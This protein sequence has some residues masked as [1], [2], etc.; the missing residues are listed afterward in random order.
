MP[1][2]VVSIESLEL[3]TTTETSHMVELMSTMAMRYLDPKQKIPCPKC[4]SGVQRDRMRRHNHSEH[5]GAQRRVHACPFIGEKMF[6]TFHDRKNHMVNIH[7]SCLVK[8]EDN[9]LLQQG[10]R[11]FLMLE[12]VSRDHS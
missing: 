11:A 12:P 10:Y 8:G 1:T 6:P 4:L 3:T 7:Q 2:L 5:Q 9:P